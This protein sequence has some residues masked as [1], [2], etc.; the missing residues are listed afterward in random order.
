MGEQLADHAHALLRRLA[1]AVDG[2][3]QTLAKGAVVVD[4]GVADVGERQPLQPADDL[5]GVD[6]PRSAC[7]RAAP[8]APVRPHLPCCQVHLAA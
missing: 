1:G 4:E 5:V 8:A 7:R 3:R 6:A 2:L